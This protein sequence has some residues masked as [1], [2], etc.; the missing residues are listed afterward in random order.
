[1]P[2]YRPTSA[3]GTPDCQDRTGGQQRRATYQDVLDAPEHKV[4]EVIDGTLYSQ[5]RPASPH[6]LGGSKLLGRIDRPFG[7]GI[8]GPGGWWIV[9]EPEIHLGDDIL[10]PDLSGWRRERMPV[11][12]NVPF[13]TL[14][15]DWVCEILSPSTRRID[16]H[17]KRPVYAREGVGHLW[18]L[19]PDERTL[20]A[21]ALH[22]SDRGK[23]WIE[24]A[25][26]QGD[27]LVSV[28]PFDAITFNLGDLWIPEHTIHEPPPKQDAA[29]A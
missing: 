7:D 11:Y 26:L 13:F 16:L 14:S 12:P 2:I 4:A 17:K 22:E 23:E 6:T 28:P 29:A 9:H 1:M 5:S 10:A 8:D 27:D 18:L 15:P 3:S 25:S 24:I 21:F 20:E 19:D